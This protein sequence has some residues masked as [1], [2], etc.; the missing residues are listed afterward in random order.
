MA[1]ESELRTTSIR[2]DPESWEQ[3]E[4]VLTKAKAFE[5]VPYGTERSDL[6]RECIDEKIAELEEQVEEFEGNSTPAAM[7]AV[8]S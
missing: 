8:E 1:D 2:V 3:F 6:I 5:V 7:V 4:R